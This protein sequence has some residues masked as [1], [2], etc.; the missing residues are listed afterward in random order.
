MFGV[1]VE[2]EFLCVREKA[3]LAPGTVTDLLLHQLYAI[4][5]SPRATFSEWAITTSTY[6]RRMSRRRQLEAQLLVLG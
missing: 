1:G 6:C 5:N 4:A 2:S 3:A